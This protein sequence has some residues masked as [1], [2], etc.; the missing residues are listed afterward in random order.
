M[1]F[2]MALTVLEH[3]FKIYFL[4]NEWVTSQHKDLTRWLKDLTSQHN[5]KT[6]KWW[7]KYATTLSESIWGIYSFEKWK[8][9]KT[10]KNTLKTDQ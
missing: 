4:T 5:N 1:I 10:I 7:Q 9:V 8:Q 6:I 3:V 2:C